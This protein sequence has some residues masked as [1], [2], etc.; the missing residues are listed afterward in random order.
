MSGARGRSLKR[1]SL[2]LP[3]SWTG[4]ASRMSRAGVPEAWRLAHTRPEI[5]RRDRPLDGS[6]AHFGTVLADAGYGT[7]RRP[8]K[9]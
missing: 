9:G 1:L 4:D 7:S 5:A 6:W 3:E 8:G 2:R